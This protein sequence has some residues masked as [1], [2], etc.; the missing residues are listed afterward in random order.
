[1]YGCFLSNR[2]SPMFL[3]KFF[4][5]LFLLDPVVRNLFNCFFELLFR[6]NPAKTFLLQE[7][8]N[9]TITGKSTNRIDIFFNIKRLGWVL[10]SRFL[11][12]NLWLTCYLYRSNFSKFETSSWL[13]LFQ[14]H[15]VQNNYYLTVDGKTNCGQ[16]MHCFFISTIS[17]VHSNW[18]ASSK[19][20]FLLFNT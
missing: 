10:V 2:S 7:N 12:R 5:Y 4:S 1:M 13:F 20:V 6:G 15:F 19:T 14:L 9:R 11:S 17:Q 16:F 8:N 18:I 3:K